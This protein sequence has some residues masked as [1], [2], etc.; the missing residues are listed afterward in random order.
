MCKPA[1]KPQ[2]NVVHV[3]WGLDSSCLIGFFV[4]KQYRSRNIFG[5]VVFMVL[6]D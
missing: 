2:T 5:V 3:A 4:A 1:T 6:F